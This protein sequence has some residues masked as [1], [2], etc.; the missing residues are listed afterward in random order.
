MLGNDG[1]V[2]IKMVINKGW[3][4]PWGIAGV[5]CKYVNVCFEEFD[6][7]LLFLRGQPSPYLKEFLRIISN[8]HIV[9]IFTFCFIG[10][11]IERRCRVL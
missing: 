9:E 3:V 10:S 2:D 1:W 4:D 5:P 6:Q 8:N 7:L 11:C